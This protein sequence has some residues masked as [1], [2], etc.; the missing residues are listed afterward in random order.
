MSS[1]KKDK[2]DKMVIVVEGVVTNAKTGGVVEGAEIKVFTNGGEK[3]ATSNNEGYYNLGELNIGSYT[4][5]ASKD[6]FLT[7]FRQVSYQSSPRLEGN[8]KEVQNL[9]LNLS[10]LTETIAFTIYKQYNYQS[11]RLAAANVPYT[12]YM[13]KFE[14]PI[15]GFSDENGLIVLNN[16]PYSAYSSSDIYLEFDFS[17]DEMTYKDIFYYSE[18]YGYTA[19]TIL[20]TNN[21]KGD[22]GIVST[23]LLDSKGISRE[24]FEIDSP[25]NVRFTQAIDTVNINDY[26]FE[27]NGYYDDLILIWADD[28]M[29][30]T[31]YHDELNY[32]RSYS[33][34]ISAIK[35]IDNSRTFTQSIDFK[36]EEME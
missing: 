25:I 5:M 13:G 3:K 31:I 21:L 28:L 11:T 27:I 7:Y 4:V 34:Y 17:E 26:S 2:F 33:L 29:E 12:L 10:P 15:T 36:T 24:D 16:M 1:C 14:D 8:S 35:N 22:L 18:I 6:S 30:V 9:I 32:N 20:G 23:N 19:K